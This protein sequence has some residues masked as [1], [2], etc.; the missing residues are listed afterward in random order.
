M[1]PQPGIYTFGLDGWDQIGPK[2]DLLEDPHV[3]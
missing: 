2:V 3:L 1:P